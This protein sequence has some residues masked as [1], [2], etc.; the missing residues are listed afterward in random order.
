[1]HI[2]QK[3]KEWKKNSAHKATGGAAPSAAAAASTDRQLLH[4]FLPRS[5]KVFWRRALETGRNQPGYAY[6]IVLR[7]PLSAQ[8][9]KSYDL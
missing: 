3:K 7:F 9:K 2:P 8:R 5:R 6:Y 1:M 4:Y